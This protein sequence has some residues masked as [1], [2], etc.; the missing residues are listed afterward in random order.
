[1]C[2]IAALYDP[3]RP[4][5]V[6]LGSLLTAALRHRGPDG[7]GVTVVG[8]ALL[9]HTRLSII[10]LEGGDQPL[11]SEDGS[12]TVV[13][14]GEIYNHKDLRRALE[15]KGHRYATHSDCEA[16][17]H[18]YEEWGVDCMRHLNGMFAFALWDDSRGR[19]LL[20][21]DAFGVK[22][23]YW[24]SDGRRVAAAS[25]IG[26]LIA[27]GEVEP[28]IDTVAL[29]HFLAWRFV[30]APRTLFRGVSKLAAASALVVERGEH[31]LIRYRE[32][33]GDPL[34]MD[35]A[36][37]AD[38]LRERLVDAVVRQ[39]MSDVPYGAFLSGGLDS[40]AVVAAMAQTATEPPA[41]FTIGFPG[42]GNAIDERA[43]ASE[44]ARLLGT[45]HRSTTMDVSDFVDELAVYVRHLEEPSGIPSAPA[46]MQLS[47]FTREHVKVVLSGQGADEPLGGYPRHRAAAALAASARIPAPLAR[48][49]QATATLLPRNER[50]KRA[51]RLLGL[52]ERRA[53]LSIF[54]ITDGALRRELRRGSED[55]SDERD[56]LV[57]AVLSDVAGRD[58]LEQALYLDTHLFLPDGLLIYGD[59]MSMAH[60]LEQRV[61]FL[62][63]EL[64]DFVERIPA[65]LRVRR[66]SNKWLY[67]QS[68]V[69]LLPPEILRRKKRP[70]ATPYDEWLRSSLGDEVARRYVESSVLAPYIDADVVK[71]LVHEHAAG[72]DDHKRVLYCLLELSQWAD[73]FL[74]G[75]GSAPPDMVRALTRGS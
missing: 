28:A 55:A 15:A 41:T 61:P 34:E 27:I 11:S 69:G 45:T 3:D 52:D 31:R 12:V 14:N 62:D 19:L 72:R 2:G 68:L 40:A 37:L 36:T 9:A 59:K 24:C 17:V 10:D 39:S 57:G 16:V 53:L 38:E 65:R 46:L 21:R 48:L 50:A 7:A 35:E 49:V 73:C 29:D 25:E 32:A 30:P 18:A 75:D 67:R 22:P 54:E 51:A 33:P 13:V 60:G 47:R 4:P 74:E 64:M 20:A 71:R 56:E 23:L 66:L 43:D 1:V 70:F 63:L 8:R 6:E 42:H 44:T 58:V 5:P 26:A